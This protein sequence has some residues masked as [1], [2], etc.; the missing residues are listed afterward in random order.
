VLCN[1]LEIKVFNAVT[2]KIILE[3]KYQEVHSKVI[4]KFGNKPEHISTLIFFW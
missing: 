2:Q 1:Q 4:Q 3:I